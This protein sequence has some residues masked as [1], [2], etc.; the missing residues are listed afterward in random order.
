MFLHISH[1]DKFID[2]FINRQRKNFNQVENIYL[3]Y[4]DS[5]N[6]RFVKSENVYVFSLYSREFWEFIKSLKFSR[7]YIHYFN[8]RLADFVLSLPE[9]IEIFWVFWGSD[10]FNLPMLLKRNFDEYSLKYCLKNHPYLL[11]KYDLT[12]F[13]LTYH[14]KNRV[15]KH[16][17][18]IQKV[19][20]FCHYSEE[21]YEIIKE[22]TGFNA[23]WLEFNYG[24]LDDFTRKDDKLILLTDYQ[25][26][27]IW[28]GNS[29][30][31]SNNHISALF[32]IKRRGIEFSSIMCPLSY[33]GHKDYAKFVIKKGRE[34]FA[35]RF[36]PLTEFMPK[37]EY[38]ELLKRCKCFIFNHKRSQAYTNIAWLLFSGGDII[39]HS[40][41][42]L[43]RYLRSNGIS[44]KTID[45]EDWSY[46]KNQKINNS[47]AIEKLLNETIVVQRYKNLF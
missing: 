46:D 40:E 44:L 5:Q 38:D 30:D 1:D 3:I 15:K 26:D 21:D 39:M 27:I 41:S 18:A 22:V 24:S 35:E 42:S 19:D 45:E 32:E 6:L 9:N 17:Q 36:I 16:L 14:W 37:E 34:L 20:Y 2:S 33:A 7:I 43:T 29:A 31:E 10:G 8:S 25:K 12:H 11:L 4:N 23:K 28:L 47:E 13:M